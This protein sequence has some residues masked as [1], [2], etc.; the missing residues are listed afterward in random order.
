MPVGL[1]C[2]K[3][4]NLSKAR[5]AFIPMIMVLLALMKN[6]EIMILRRNEMDKEKQSFNC[7]L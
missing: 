7:N 2:M 1:K 5:T 3:V 6:E 4:R